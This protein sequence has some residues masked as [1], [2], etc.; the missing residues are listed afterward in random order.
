MNGTGLLLVLTGPSGAGKSS[1]VKALLAAEPGLRFSVSHTTRPARPG[2]RDGIDYRFVSER[3][4]DAVRAAGGFVEWAMV[5]GHLYGTAHGEIE[6]ALKSGEQVLL[7]ID[8]QGAEQVKRRFP[9]AVS[10]FM[11]PPDFAA[12]EARLR[13]RRTESDEAL[14][15]RLRTAC[16]EVRQYERFTYALVNDR[17]ET[18]ASEVRAILTAER[19]RVERRRGALEAILATFPPA[20]PNPPDRGAAS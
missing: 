14:A 8:V 4:F 7:D 5:H 15:K 17:V 9:Q 19:A 13:G 6:G 10:I 16:A 1:V 11:L 3:D 12:L 2:E 18:A 20:E